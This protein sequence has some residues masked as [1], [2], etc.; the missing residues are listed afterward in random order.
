M[1]TAY[2]SIFH[3]GNE[4]SDEPFGRM[5]MGI[6]SMKDTLLMAVATQKFAKQTLYKKQYSIGVAV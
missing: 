4:A 1:V 3:N 6:V 5:V 2:L